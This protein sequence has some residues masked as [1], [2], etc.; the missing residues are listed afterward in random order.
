[1]IRILLTYPFFENLD[2]LYVDHYRKAITQDVCGYAESELV[3]IISRFHINFSKIPITS[4]IFLFTI[5]IT[6]IY[7]LN[8]LL[9][10]KITPN[11]R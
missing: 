8:L 11:F 1:M 7:S 5:L 10:V 6:F 4:P 3:K 2:I 9:L